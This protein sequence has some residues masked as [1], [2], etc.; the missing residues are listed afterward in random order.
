MSASPTL[1]LRSA[2]KSFGAVRALD[3]VTLELFPG[4]VH[5]LAGANG[6]GKSTLIKLLS[7]VYDDYEGELSLDGRA[8]RFASPL[9]AARAGIATIHQ[10]LS[11]VPTLSV[12]DN[13]WLTQPGSALSWTSG[14]AATAHAERACERVDLRIDPDTL[15][16]S[17]AVGD[18]QL[19]EI[20]RALTLPSLR[21]LILDEP[22][23]ALSDPAAS[24]LFSH[25]E[26]LRQ[27]GLAIVYISHRMTEIHH[28]ADRITVLRDGRH[29][30]TRKRGELDEADLVRAMVGRDPATAHAAVASRP[31]TVRL[32]VQNLA[33]G[34]GTVSFEL[35]EGEV[36]GVAGLVGSLASELLHRLFAASPL[37]GE[38]TLDGEPYAP[39]DPMEALGRGV[40][41]L[42]SDRALS[43][44]PDLSLLDNATLSSL[45]RFCRFGFVDRARQ[46]EQVTEQATALALR[47]ASWDRDARQLSGGNQQ[48]LAWL[49]CLM[50]NPRVLLLDDPTRGIDVGARGEIYARVTELTARG[51]A[52]LVYSSDLDELCRICDRVL[53]LHRGRITAE[54]SRQEFDRERMLTAMLGGST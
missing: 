9:E 37:S 20:A 44:L 54:F 39:H 3:D 6:A 33:L 46:R 38:V 30:L 31:G 10:E 18:R 40:A 24:R 27:Q 26:R 45:P 41:L 28:L 1:K 47:P 34:A 23:S 5:V 21:V 22:T 4:E 14:K 42:A 25:L 53:C 29:V 17:L 35:G 51:I 8:V 16:E 48:K 12:A 13:L 43:V 7:G 2:G 32:A 50:T 52:V 36:L 49:R 11:L 19:L 15:V